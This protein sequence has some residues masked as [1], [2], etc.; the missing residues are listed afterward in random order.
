MKGI[1]QFRVQDIDG[2]FSGV[3]AGLK[4]LQI[5]VVD[6]KMFVGL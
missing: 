6:Q 4:D 5:E 1:L 2:F 3:S